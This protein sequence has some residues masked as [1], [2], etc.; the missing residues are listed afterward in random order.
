MCDPKLVREMEGNFKYLEE[1]VLKYAPK[2]T[3]RNYLKYLRDM[4]EKTLEEEPD[5]EL[6]MLVNSS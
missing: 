1:K 5:R 2:C 4:M 3:K 6:G